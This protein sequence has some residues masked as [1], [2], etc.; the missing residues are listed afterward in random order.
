MDTVIDLQSLADTHD[1][2]FIVIDRDFTVVAVNKAYEQVFGIARHDAV[3]RRCYEVSRGH[4]RP[5]YE[6]GEDCPCQ[7]IFA[8]ESPHDC[9]HIHRQ[10]HGRPTAIR[11]QVHPL[12]GNDGQIYLAESFQLIAQPNECGPTAMAGHSPAFLGSLEALGRAAATKVPALL[13]GESGTGKELA[14]H[15]IHVNS[16]RRQGPFVTLDCTALAEGLFENEVFGHERGSYTGSAGEQAGLVEVA[17]GGT[18]F[19]DEV[20]ELPRAQQAKFLRFLDSGEFRRVGGTRNRR[21]DVRIVCATNRELKEMAGFRRDLYYRIA[22]TTI[23]LPPLRERL[24]DIPDLAPVLLRPLEQDT[25]RVFRLDSD[26]ERLLKGYR[27]PGNIRELRNLLWEAASRSRDGV[28]N[29]THFPSLGLDAVGQ[30]RAEPA[31]E[32][33]GAQGDECWAV[34][35]GSGS[36]PAQIAGLLRRHHGNRR[37]V[38]AT[39]GISERTLYRKLNRY[40]L[41]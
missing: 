34:E 26:A 10:I 7:Q 15:Y 29:E 40:G 38:A 39:L 5:C 37:R 9:L 17:E 24:E 8:G 11:V 6:L 12:R 19:L 25:G 13:L 32:A 33:T 31:G 36:E 18:L 20:G 27:Y 1:R 3:G 14:A 41:R 30:E 22:C 28:L 21:T 23:R 35:G 16:C 4:D 2:A